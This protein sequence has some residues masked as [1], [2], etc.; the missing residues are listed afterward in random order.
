MRSVPPPG[1]VSWSSFAKKIT[2]Y[3]QPSLARFSNPRQNFDP[4]QKIHLRVLQS[5]ESWEFK[6]WFLYLLKGGI[7]DK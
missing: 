1:R 3:D 2:I 4:P 6:S 7:R 5:N